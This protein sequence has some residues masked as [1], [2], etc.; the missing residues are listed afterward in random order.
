VRERKRNHSVIAL[1]TSPRMPSITFTERAPV[2]FERGE[3]NPRRADARDDAAL[4]VEVVARRIE[5]A[6]REK[7][8]ICGREIILCETH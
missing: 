3:R 5:Q 1:L 6:T 8:V 4:D 2:L 7:H